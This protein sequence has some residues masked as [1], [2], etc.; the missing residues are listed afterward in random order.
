M[1]TTLCLAGKLER[2][3]RKWTAPV[4]TEYR[5]SLPHI[6][7]KKSGLL[8]LVDSGAEISLV[9]PLP[10]ERRNKQVSNTLVTVSGSPIATFGFRTMYISF[11]NIT[12]FRWIFVIADVSRNILGVD[13]FESFWV[14]A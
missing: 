6:R 5:S 7:D 3:H 10:H 12:T 4:V 2:H 11:D 9:K 1:S 8:F 13:F 14:V